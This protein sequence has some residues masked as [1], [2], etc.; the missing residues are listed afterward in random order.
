MGESGF[1][2]AHPVVVRV[3]MLVS[4]QASAPALWEAGAQG[5]RFLATLWR[6]PEEG[7][8]GHPSVDSSVCSMAC[9]S[10]T[11]TADHI[12]SSKGLR[13]AAPYTGT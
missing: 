4:K 11:V 6:H 12:T 3:D 2:V 10:L 8:L 7:E 5:K 1:R 13:P 9:A